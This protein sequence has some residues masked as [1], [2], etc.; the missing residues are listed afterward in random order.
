MCDLRSGRFSLTR[1]VSK[2]EATQFASRMGLPFYE[3]SAKENTNVDEL[4]DAL[5]DRMWNPDEIIQEEN[6]ELT[7]LPEASQ[8]QKKKKTCC[9]FV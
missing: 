9:C 3:T 2:E 7:R 5:V 4:F 1:E 8:S 6:D